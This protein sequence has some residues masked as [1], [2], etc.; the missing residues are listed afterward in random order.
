MHWKDFGAAWEE[1]RGTQFGCG[2]GDIALGEGVIGLP[3][4]AAELKKIG[5]DGPTTLEIFGEANV[6]PSAERL[7]EWFS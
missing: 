1:K 3:E 2:M 5:F 4:I 6:V 7:R